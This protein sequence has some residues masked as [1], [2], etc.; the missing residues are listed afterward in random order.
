MRLRFFGG[1]AAEADGAPLDIRGRGQE[2]LL[3]RLAL[4]AGTTVAY[5]SLAEDVWPDDLPEDPRAAL[6]SLASRLRRGLPAGTLEAVPGGYRLA[7]AREEVDLAQFQDLVARARRAADPAAATSDARAALDLWRGDP[8][9]PGHGFDW[10]VRDLL[11]DRAHAERIL[12]VR[13]T[14]AGDPGVARGA[15]DSSASGVDAS[16]P[17]ALTPLIGRRRELEL[18]GEQLRDERLVTLIGPGGA[19]KT[20]LA[21]ETARRAPGSVVVELAPAAPGEVWAAVAG[22][23]GRSIRVGE[24]VSTSARDRVAE[25][26]AG[27]TLLVVLDNCEHVS[28]EAAAVALDVLRSAPGSRILATSREPLGLAGEAFVDLG[29]LPDP[30]A[31]ELFSRRVRAARGSAPTPDEEA[32]VERIVT[33][34]DGLPLAL[35]LAAAKSRTL[36]LAEIDSGL[37]D[38]FALLATGPKAIEA[39]HQTLRALIDWSW[40]TLTDAERTAL[41]AAAVFPDGV[42]VRDVPAIGDAFDVDADA[43]DGLVDKSLLRRSDRRLRMLETVRE[44]GIDRL[45]TEGREAEFRAV[46]ARAMA[47]LAAR[48]DARLRGPEV[49]EALAW[50]DADDENLSAALRVCADQ[51]GMEDVGVRVVR[52]CL[53]TWLMR[54]RFEELQSGVMRFGEA[55]ASL[56]SEAAVVVRAIALLGSAFARDL[57]D[58]VE[59]PPRLGPAASSSSADTGGPTAGS[60]DARPGEPTAAGLARFEREVPAV[61]EAAA[62]HRSELSAALG[63][64]LR[65]VLAAAQNHRPG[66][67]WSRNVTIGDEGLED[68][69][70][71][72]L[73][74]ISMLR[75]AIAQNG[76]DNQTLGAESEKAVSTFR[77]LGDVWGT[78]FASQMRSEWLQLAGRLDEALAVA[79]A[80]SAGLLGLT[81]VTDLVQQ[82]SQSIGLLLRL[83]RLDEARARLH[84]SQELARTKDSPRAIAQTDMDAAAIEIAVGDGAA[85]LRH[86]DIVA[87]E[88]LPSFPDQLIAWS[89]SRRAQALLLEGRADEAHAALAEALPAAARSGDHPIVAD[90]AV[91]IAGWLATTGRDADARRAL[92]AAAR[93]RGGVD[94]SDPFLRVMRERLGNDVLLPDATAPT[95]RADSDGDDDIAALVALLA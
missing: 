8:W 14:D 2:A 50:F 55:A 78:A 7:V 10:V 47:G 16:V 26:L 95:S 36:T 18:I 75:S 53:W 3:F 33:R 48:E 17:A 23:V 81:S 72:T 4:D 57:E 71:W 35:E 90:V 80:S 62:V 69:P 74:L 92:V 21:F 12:A 44:Y 46:Q 45:R 25:A 66:A 63:P 91:S 64:L 88:M 93:L 28:A 60:T 65:A 34:L 77:E 15:E 37:D 85:A 87:A 6:Q 13:G 42:D 20:T 54:E 51:P 70:T 43:F 82:R 24:L 56:D 89:R 79:D 68:A 1:L 59:G 27:R 32:A 31:R 86:L 39:R 38:R 29:P 30:D 41:R 76:G 19:G 67:P 22:A 49:R 11:E 83:G 94:A 61:I 52:S 73:A 9:T 40:E 84:E 5:R 58:A